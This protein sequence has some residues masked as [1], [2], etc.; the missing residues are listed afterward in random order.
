MI[1]TRI[2]ITKNEA[3]V[4]PRRPTPVKDEIVE[5][6]THALTLRSGSDAGVRSLPHSAIA[7]EGRDAYEQIGSAE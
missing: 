2:D 5:K 6:S 7:F 1:K 3:A 4:Y